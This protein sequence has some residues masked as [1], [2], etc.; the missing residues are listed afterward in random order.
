MFAELI[1]VRI[2][3]S[4]IDLDG[5][6]THMQ[7]TIFHPCRVSSLHGFCIPNRLT[8]PVQKAMARIS[9][10]CVHDSF[11]A[12][13]VALTKSIRSTIRTFHNLP[14]ADLTHSHASYA[15]AKERQ[16]G[17]HLLPLLL[18][19]LEARKMEG[20]TAAVIIN[21]VVHERLVGHVAQP[22]T[23]PRAQGHP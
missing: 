18:Q 10:S 15:A 7:R 13:T 14:F 8:T 4:C 22:G 5:R 23:L 1:P 2:S 16:K 19:R 6:P 21:V 12:R 20:E 3:P 17:Q 11:S 9:I